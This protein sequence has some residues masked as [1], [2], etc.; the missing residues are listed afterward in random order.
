MKKGVTVKVS[1]FIILI[2]ALLFM[3]IIIKLSY[4]VLSDKV[5][6]ISLKEKAASIA[7]VEKTL[8]ASRGNI[9]DVNGE[10]L[11]TTVNSYTVIAYLS[12]SRT[13]DP[14]NPKHVVDKEKTAELLSPI[15]NMTK[16]RLLALLNK[17]AYQVE[18]GPGGRGITEVVKAQIEKLEL[19]GI[20]FISNSKKRYYSKATFASYIVG[21]AKENKDGK[22]TGELGIEGYYDEILSGTNGYTKYLKYTSSNYQIPN[23]PSETKKAQNGSDIYLTIDSNIQLIAEKAVSNMQN[24]FNT[25]WASFTVMDAKTGAIVASSTSPNFNPNDT[26]TIK[27]YMNPLVSY[28][29]EPGSVMKIFS[30]A[31]AIEE[32]LYNGAETFKSGSYTLDDGTIIRDATRS[33]WGEIDFDLGF[34][35]SSN[36]AATIL[37]LRLGVNKLTNYYNNLGF[38]QKTGIELSNEAKGDISFRYQ[39]E[40]SNASFGQGVS[41]TPIQ[42]LEALSSMTNNGSTIK[43]YIV[44][45]IVDQDGNITYKGGRE[46]VEKVYSSSTVSKMQE[47]MKK[48]IEV[49]KVWQVNN[50][51]IMGKTGTAQIAS[52]SGG[53]LSGTYDYIKSFA[54]IFPTDD[55]KYIVY[56][57]GKKPETNLGSW[58]RVITTA[59][60]EIAS[61]AKL[62]E[63]KTDVDKTKLITLDNYISKETEF[64]TNTLKE[65]KINAIVLGNGKF[66][67][68]QYP[69]KNKTILSGGKVFLLTNA[70][71]Y[72][73]ENL[74]GWSLNEVE[75][76]ANLL[77]IKLEYSGYGYVISQSIAPG[78]IIDKENTVLS[79][80]LNK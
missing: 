39:S 24:D 59:V 4:V 73:M 14:S 15:I 57:V 33:G 74:Q 11:A 60:E 29:Y 38:G 34:A 20:S 31:S 47:L 68:N 27:S 80:E 18:L 21:Y 26:N 17:D 77:G 71:E 19:P 43:P 30:F 28:Q 7:T 76:F 40:L 45:K 1:R 63:T 65:N 72:A 66:I 78:T 67:T 70:T 37:A 22:L 13:T 48:V 42:M 56:V 5:D 79:V 25:D 6:G 41:I 9:F 12:E 64:V 8:Y 75:T 53:Y 50:V 49:N 3:A 58:A 32:N 69:L 61:Y 16:E 44:D 46:V 52:P 23:T 51:S 55:P 36:V 10:E 2:V 35:H 54:G 62:T